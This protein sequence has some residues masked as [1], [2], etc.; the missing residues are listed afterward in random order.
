MFN[1]QIS[2]FQEFQEKNALSKKSDCSNIKSTS[3]TA[4]NSPVTNSLEFNVFLNN[5]VKNCFG[6]E[7]N[8]E[9]L[10]IQEKKITPPK[11]IKKIILSQKL[12]KNWKEN[13][14][15][16][17]HQLQIYLSKVMSNNYNL[18]YISNCSKSNGNFFNAKTS[19]FQNSQ[20]KNN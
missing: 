11:Q 20:D 12:N 15:R 14:R 3:S 8:Q 19:Y 1:N 2:L 16:F 9:N 13:C 10:S 17:R 7:E 5:V 6:L 4:L 18:K